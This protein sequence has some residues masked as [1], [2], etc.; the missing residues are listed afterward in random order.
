MIQWTFLLLCATLALSFFSGTAADHPDHDP[1]KIDTAAISKDEQDR[2][3]SFRSFME[4]CDE[5]YFGDSDLSRM[6]KEHK[7]LSKLLELV[8]M[9][10]TVIDQR[11]LEWN[12]MEDLHQ[13]T[14][15]LASSPSF[16]KIFLKPPSQSEFDSI[17]HFDIYAQERSNDLQDLRMFSFSPHRD[18]GMVAALSISFSSMVLQ[19]IQHY[20]GYA[21]PTAQVVTK[22]A[23]IYSPIIEV[24]AGNGYWSA[25]LE[26]AGA[27]VL[28][29]D[30]EPPRNNDNDDADEDAAENPNLFSHVTKPFLRVQQG[31]CTEVFS[32]TTNSSSD[33]GQRALLMIWPNNPDHLDNPQHHQ[34]GTTTLPIWD[35]DCLRAYLDAGG[36]MVIYVGERQ[37]QIQVRRDFPPDVGMSSS[38]KFQTTL[39]EKFTLVE[40]LDIPVWWGVDDVTV[41]KRTSG[42]KDEL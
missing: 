14:L 27:D 29:F 41:W 21:T 2:A 38:K 34:E 15:A 28:A 1:T 20:A 13:K 6:Q 31:S 8:G 5:L 18:R 22:L 17:V 19:T 30:S 35:V 11:P 10:P 26:L 24:G 32:T 9:D 23:T 25:A 33:F 36:S 39:Q 4:A 16:W 37:A 12:W 40:Q 3:T 42:N 7:V